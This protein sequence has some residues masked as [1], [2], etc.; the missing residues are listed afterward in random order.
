MTQSNNSNDALSA[1]TVYFKDHFGQPIQNLKVEI[2]GLESKAEH[3]YHSAST[4]AQGAVEFSA[5]LGDALSVHVKRWT[6]DGMKE[7]ARLNATLSQI[8]FHLTSPK[9]LHDLPTKTDDGA[10]GNYWRG[11]YKVKAHD[12]LTVIAHKY[13]TSVDLLKHVNNL[14]SDL[15]KVGQI[16]KVP[17]VQSRKSDAP[18]PK[19]PDP[20]GT[21]P[22]SDPDNNHK[23]APTTTPRKGAA[24]IIFPVKVRPLNDE[25]AIYGTPNCNY[26]WNK[27]LG[28]PGHQT[29]RFGAIRDTGGRKHA[30]RDLYLEKHTEVVAIAAGVVIK[31]ELFYSKTN[32]ISVHHTT[33]DGRQFIALYGEVAP[34][35]IQVKVGSIVNQGDVLAKS[36]VLLHANNTPLHIVG[37]QNVSMLHF[38]MYSGQGGFDPHSTI[39]SSTLPG[40]FHR[41]SDLIDSLAI[42]E[43]GYHATFLDAPPLKPV[44]DRIPIAQLKTSD[45]GKEFIKCW[46]SVKYDS[47]KQNTYYYND[48][49]GFCTVGWG[50]LI[51]RKS[52]ASLGFT[53]DVSKISVEEAQ[54]LFQKDILTHEGYVT[55]AIKVPLYQ[56]EFDALVSL[57]FNVGHI[58]TVAPKLCQKVNSCDYAG[59]PVEFLDMDI[60][61]RRKREHD[62]FCNGTYDASH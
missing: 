23:G 37:N 9:T 22:K 2:K 11:T 13:H 58:G 28:S 35:T 45:R 4:N 59:A 39:N 62:M 33:T 19:K 51:D 36:G 21:P 27:P 20:K 40:P 49:N 46:E 60:P 34:E 38:E 32:Q 7:I 55:S 52:C 53:A 48:K 44:G 31:C 29:P 24:P 10:S 50:S 15:I 42:L 17:P 6:S 26:I 3:I 47:T 61:K 30:A 1:V 8:K 43:E 25:G 54:A 16:L 12:N 57:A 41:R 56:H 18:A 5:R 14:K